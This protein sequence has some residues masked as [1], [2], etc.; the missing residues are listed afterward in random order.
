[1]HTRRNFLRRVGEGTTFLA[2]KIVRGPRLIKSL[3][4]NRKFIQE[5]LEHALLKRH[6]VNAVSVHHSWQ[7]SVAIGKQLR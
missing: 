7:A 5:V 6:S 4:R 3:V 2:V 1:M